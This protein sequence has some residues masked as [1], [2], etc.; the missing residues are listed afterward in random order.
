MLGFTI[1]AT[2]VFGIV[3]L[4]GNAIQ[5]EDTALGALAIAASLVV[6]AVIEVSPL[7]V[8]RSVCQRQTPKV[9][10]RRFHPSL[11][12]LLWGLDT[13]AVVTTYR[14]SMATWAVLL[15]CA[16]GWGSAWTGTFYAVGFCV[17]LAAIVMS[18]QIPRSAAWLRPAIETPHVVNAIGSRFALVLWTSAAITVLSALAVVV[19][20]V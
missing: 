9:L 19:S 7:R 1:S 8:R 20:A 12:G 11:G 17:P 15:L 2:L 13:G 3:A 14:V 4:V 6:L 18:P 5:L 10:V 16:G